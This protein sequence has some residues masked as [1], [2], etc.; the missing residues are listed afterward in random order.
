MML[1]KY[2]K[3]MQN[4]LVTHLQNTIDDGPKQSLSYVILVEQPI[5][6]EIEFQKSNPMVRL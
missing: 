4:N 2:S 3:A 1:P 6:R 5:I